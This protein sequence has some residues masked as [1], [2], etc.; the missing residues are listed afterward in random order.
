MGDLAEYWFA[1]GS[2]AFKAGIP[3]S[4]LESH[5]PEGDM[6]P[7]EWRALE[8]GWVAERIKTLEQSGQ[9]RLF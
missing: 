5:Y 7:G 9:T 6:E 3:L 2:Y 1:E 8:Q 4:Q